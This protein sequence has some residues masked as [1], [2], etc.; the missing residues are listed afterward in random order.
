M[1]NQKNL[2]SYKHIF[3]WD[4]CKRCNGHHSFCHT[5][6]YSKF[7]H[8][9]LCT[10]HCPWRTYGLMGKRDTLSWVLQKSMYKAYT[11]SFTVWLLGT[12]K[13]ANKQNLSV[14]RSQFFSYP[15]SASKTIYIHICNYKIL[16]GKYTYF[17]VDFKH[18]WNGEWSTVS[19][20]E[21]I[22]LYL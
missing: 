3:E 21:L 17:S 20:A 11:I 13:Q 2:V 6:V 22:Y 15:H 1:K 5:L 14:R 18:S 4:L 7:I 8:H 16:L 10:W 12:D 9:L 19:I